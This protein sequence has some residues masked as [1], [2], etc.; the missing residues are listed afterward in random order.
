MSV[1]PKQSGH[2]IPK[3]YRHLMSNSDSPIIDFYP[4]DF[5]LDINGARYA[6]MGVDLLPFIDRPRLLK[7]MSE[8]D[9]GY[10]KLTENE[11]IRNKRIGDIS[12][13]FEKID[14]SESSLSRLPDSL[15]APAEESKEQIFFM[16]AFA[17]QD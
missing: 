14:E 8:A 11:K 7:A 6:W 3:C 16:A 13:F 17:N 4:I 5:R 15:K 9:Q 2:A 10:E 12:L 1:F